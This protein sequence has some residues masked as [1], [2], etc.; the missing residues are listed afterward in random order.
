MKEW[1]MTN[2]TSIFGMRWCLDILLL[3]FVPA[4]CFIYLLPGDFK[5]V[6]GLKYSLAPA[7]TSQRAPAAKKERERERAGVGP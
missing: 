7:A 1:K 3:I 2:N 5:L 6:I 4:I